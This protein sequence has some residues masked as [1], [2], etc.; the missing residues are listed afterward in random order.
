MKQ[1]SIFSGIKYVFILSLLL[2]GFGSFAQQ[3]NTTTETIYN[4]WYEWPHENT[5]G[6][7]VY[8]TVKYTPVP[9]I[10]KQ[11][12]PFSMLIIKNDGTFIKTQYCGYCPALKIEE[13]KGQF[14]IESV[15][16]KTN[17]KVTYNSSK[18]PAPLEV[19][20]ASKD[21]LVL[22][23]QYEIINTH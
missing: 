16:G 13:T 17:I 1:G 6:N 10:D 14:S 20:S 21:K 3:A 2:S 8:K 4:T 7:T 22:N 18:S 19:V 11:D 5:N 12:E 15:K 23:L 9:G